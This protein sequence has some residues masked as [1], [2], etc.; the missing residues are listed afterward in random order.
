MYSLYNIWNAAYRMSWLLLTIALLC[1]P[2]TISKVCAQANDQSKTNSQ[3][4]IRDKEKLE[5][6]RSE[7]KT[8]LADFKAKRY[9]DALKRFNRVYRLQPHPNLV[10]NMA[11]S[12]EELKE[13]KSIDH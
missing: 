7:Y 2:S 13:Y 1:C 8:G 9:R 3:K 10:Y 5:I 6:A 11:R 4:M 12:F